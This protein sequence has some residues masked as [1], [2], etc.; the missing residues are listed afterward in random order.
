MKIWL[1]SLIAGKISIMDNPIYHCKTPVIVKE[2][3][4]EKIMLI[5]DYH[6]INSIT[7]NFYDLIFV[8]VQWAISRTM[9]FY[10]NIIHHTIM[11]I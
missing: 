2:N 11:Y 1:Q 10:I 8:Y 3:Y 5:T 9:Y 7:Y 4:M 6:E